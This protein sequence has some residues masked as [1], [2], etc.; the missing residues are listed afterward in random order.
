MNGWDT[1]LVRVRHRRCHRAWEAHTIDLTL[2]IGASF[3]PRTRLGIAWH[4]GF[5]QLLCLLHSQIVLLAAT[6]HE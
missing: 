5:E 6:E 2:P 1:F 3:V 4:F